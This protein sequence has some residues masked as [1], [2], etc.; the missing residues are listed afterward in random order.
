VEFNER[1]ST[2]ATE[3]PVEDYVHVYL[4]PQQT[5]YVAAAAWPAS[6]VGDWW[7]E[8]PLVAD[9]DDRSPEELRAPGHE[10]IFQG[11]KLRRREE[12]MLESILCLCWMRPFCFS[13][14]LHQG[15]RQL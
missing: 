12:P 6:I 4:W 13:A 3:S 11:N 15:L 8:G 10:V 14:G 2:L 7:A 5:R 1:V 9:T